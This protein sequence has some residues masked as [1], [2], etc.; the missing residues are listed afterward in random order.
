MKNCFQSLLEFTTSVLLN[1][2]H[3][4][5]STS[6]LPVNQHSIQY[7]NFYMNNYTRL[8]LST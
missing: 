3:S 8:F 7:Q 4:F 2:I 6:I 5:F 1:I